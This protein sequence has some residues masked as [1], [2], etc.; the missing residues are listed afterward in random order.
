ME[1]YSTFKKVF[2]RFCLWIVPLRVFDQSVQLRIYPNYIIPSLDPLVTIGATQIWLRRLCNLC[3]GDLRNIL[4][5]IKGCC[6]IFLIY[7]DQRHTGPI[8]EGIRNGGS[9]KNGK[10]QR[11]LVLGNLSL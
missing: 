4:L 7:S 3:E 11:T 5:V 8:S 9:Y 6:A 2:S 1:W 10:N